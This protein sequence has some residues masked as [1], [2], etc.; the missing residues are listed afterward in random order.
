ME[1]IYA[2]CARFDVHQHSVVA[3]ARVGYASSAKQFSP[4]VTQSPIT[5]IRCTPG[6][7]VV[8]NG[9]AAK[10]V[11]V[12]DDVHAVT[13]PYIHFGTHDVGQIRVVRRHE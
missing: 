11:L 9:R 4:K 3:C 13:H 12:R 1:V 6:T 5:R 8:E 10:A 2:Q 7:G